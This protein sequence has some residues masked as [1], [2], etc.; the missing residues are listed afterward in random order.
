M[1]VIE[2]VKLFMNENFMEDISLS[3]LADIGN[4]SVFH[5]NRLFKKLTD[6]TPYKYL[7]SVRLQLAQLQLKNTSQ[8]VT[9][10]A[11]ASGFKSLDHF[12][13]TYKDHFGKSPSADRL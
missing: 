2:R 1:P 3:Q 8:P 11:F 13:A 12:S 4:M 6:Y 5:F 7:L 10:V 9:E